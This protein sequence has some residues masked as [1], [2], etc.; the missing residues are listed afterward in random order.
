L[1]I[2]FNIVAVL[3]SVVALLGLPRLIKGWRGLLAPELSLEA[4]G[5]AVYV[6][7]FLAV[8]L[9]T[10]GHELGH[11]LAARVLGAEDATLHYRVFWGY[12]EHNSLP[13]RGNWWVALAGNA[14]SWAAAAVSLLL[15]RSPLP[16]GLSYTARIFGLFEMIHVL[17]A[18]PLFSLGDFPGADWAVIYG[19]PFWMGTWAVAAVHAASLLW[20]RREV[21]ALAA[22]VP[23]PSEPDEPQGTVPPST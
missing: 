19:R 2:R 12:V 20:L 18:Y 3:Y 13:G 22:L 9:A 14:V 5:L 17:V 16:P 21:H 6:A 8:P 11:L 4:R 7:L 10:L 1:D 23:P 15:A